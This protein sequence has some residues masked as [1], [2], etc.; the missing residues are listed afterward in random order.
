VL[1]SDLAGIKLQQVPYT[2]LNQAAT[3]LI[4]A[5][6]ALWIATL[7]GH[8]GNIKAGN[9]RALAVSG[10][11]RSEQLPDVPTFKELGIAFVDETSWYG[12]YAPR[13]TPKPIIERINADVAGALALPA[14]QA[15]MATLGFRAFG[16]PP[17]KLAAMLAGE[18]AK[19]AEV[20]KSASL[21]AK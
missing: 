10:Q 11:S 15:R 13:G 9:V 1:F 5:R 16:G 21:V 4:S 3:D 12:I 2:S 7:G 8:L 19:W 18:I 20:A 6:I 14:V 17:D